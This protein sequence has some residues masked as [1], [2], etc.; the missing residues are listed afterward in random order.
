M[1]SIT[2]KNDGVECTVSDDGGDCT[3]Y[4][5]VDLIK[6]CLVGVGFHPDNVDDVF[7]DEARWSLPEK[8][9]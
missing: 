8:T 2:L 7:H 1:R 9:E 6:Q 3:I 4:T 5:Y